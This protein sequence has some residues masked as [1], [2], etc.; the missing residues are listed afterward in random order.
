MS[1][2]L[3][4]YISLIDKSFRESQTK[5]YTM[6]MQLSLYG[7]VFCIFSEDRNKYIGFEAYS[8]KNIEDESKIPSQLDLILNEKP[9]FA[10]PFK[11][12]NLLYQNTS[13][14][15]V[16]GVLFDKT[17][18][19]LYLGF[20][21][22]FK[23]NS[24]IVFDEL[25]TALANNVY[26]LPNP[27]A[28]KIKEFWPNADIRH[29]SSIL[30]ES[31]LIN[32]KNKIGDKTLFVN[33]REN[34]FDLVNFKQNKLNYYNN[35][36]FRTKEDFIYFLLSA[37]ENLGLNPEEVELVLMGEINK[38]MNSYE[39]IFQYIRNFSFVEK[40][41]SLSYSYLLDEV[42]HH[43]YNTLFSRVQCE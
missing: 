30:I 27:V 2:Q 25:K 10:F 20:N 37:I 31:L 12:F 17:K 21:Q 36:E 43:S 6:S 7:L 16:P 38:G 39:M 1:L 40:N 28:E 24:R 18:K 9:W 29:F 34:S 3:K 19:S 22:P 26:Y 14:T 35:F 8:F 23:E 15:L 4:P 32:Y 41:E 13:N 11:H 33:V 42:N 5:N